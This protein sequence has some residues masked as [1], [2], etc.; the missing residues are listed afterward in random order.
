M[1]IY[2]NSSR[3]KPILKKENGKIEKIEYNADNEALV[4]SIIR[5]YNETESK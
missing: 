3:Y 4:K 1:I 5:A 2:N